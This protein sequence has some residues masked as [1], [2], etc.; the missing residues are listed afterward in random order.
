[1][2]RLTNEY[3]FTD[4]DIL[5]QQQQ[6]TSY[7]QQKGFA[8]DS[9]K[10]YSN[11]TGYFLTWLIT[12]GITAEATTY[13]DLLRFINHCRKEGRS[14]KNTN[15]VLTALRHYYSMVQVDPDSYR[16]NPAANLY[17]KGE[18]QRIPHDLLEKEILD[19]LYEKYQ[20]YNE[21]TQR[22]KVILGLYIY[23]A[24]ATDELKKLE[25]NHIKLKEGKIYIPG[26]KQTISK[27]GRQARWLKLEAKQI[28]DL[29]EYL[30]VTRPKIIDDI[31]SG[32]RKK[33]STRKPD[34]INT[35][36]LEH[37][38]FISLNGSDEIKTSVRFLMDD[39]RKINPSVKDAKQIRKSVITEWLKEKDIRIVQYM[40]GHSSISTTERY[41]AA[42]VEELEEALKIHHPLK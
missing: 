18:V 14:V 22:N 32:E 9:C 27:G 23:Q 39:L 42:N 19:Y 34:N 5:G 12:Q 2:K 36:A 30:L 16:D 38:L 25:P 24:I 4:L 20:T 8:L 1:M 41:R 7:L 21:R 31:K 40:A 6:L 11:Y 37:Q 29:Q 17:L 28:L 26:T 13:N 10:M 33:Q 15:L 3:T 35:S